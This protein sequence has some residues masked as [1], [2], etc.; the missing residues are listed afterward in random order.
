VRCDLLLGED[1][2]RAISDTC[3]SM[4]GT[5]EALRAGAAGSGPGSPGARPA[6]NAVDAQRLCAEAGWPGIERAGGRV[7][8]AL[9]VPGLFHEAIL[10]PTDA[11]GIRA[12]VELGAAPEHS[13][14]GRDAAARFLLAVS[15][16]VRLVRPSAV[17]V[18]S[19]FALRYEAAWAVAPSPAELA[20]SLE[21]LS[22]ACRACAREVKALRDDSVAAAYVARHERTP[23]HPGPASTAPRGDACA[24]GRH[25]TPATTS[26]RSNGGPPVVAQRRELQ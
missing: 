20:S 8:V 2:P 11:G 15:A 26:T 5:L 9:E 4:T 13:D 16:V 10:A 1:G 19:G 21:A 18:D 25:T 24:T 6:E 23:P 14:I 12:H 17:P 3:R 22:V 7:A